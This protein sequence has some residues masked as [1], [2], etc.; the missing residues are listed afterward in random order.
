MFL[1]GHIFHLH[2]VA[3]PQSDPNYCTGMSGLPWSKTN[4]SDYGHINIFVIFLKRIL[5]P[6]WPHFVFQNVYY[7]PKIDLNW[8]IGRYIM[9]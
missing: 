6:D 9:F 2:D 4:K 5:S 3:N 7:H 8:S 1:P